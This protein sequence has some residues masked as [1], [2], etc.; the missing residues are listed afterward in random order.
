M[1]INCYVFDNR[2][3]YLHTLEDFIG[4]T[5]NLQFAGQSEDAATAI[6]QVVSGRP[7][8]T[9]YNIDIDDL[10]SIQTIE[11]MYPHTCIIF[12]TE[13]EEMALRLYHRFATDFIVAPLSYPA[14]F[15]IVSK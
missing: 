4:R 6:N 3:R 15:R 12:I 5:V 13:T 9:F 11:M 7:D 1:I 14:F 8:I 2:A 10:P